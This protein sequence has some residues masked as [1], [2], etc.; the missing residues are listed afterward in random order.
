MLQSSILL[1]SFATP[2][3]HIVLAVHRSPKSFSTELLPS[4]IDLSLCCSPG[5]CS[6]V[7]D[8][9][10]VELHEVVS[11]LFQLIQVFLQGGCPF[12]TV[13]FPT[14]F[15]VFI[16]LC[17]TLG[18]IVQVTY[19]KLNSIGPNIYSW[20]PHSWQVSSFTGSC[21]SAPSECSL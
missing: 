10:F 14:W 15:G 12:W 16:R 5:L 8:L 17:V 4:Q 1:A 7:Q 20:S 3:A 6:R 9:M 21:F 13:N 2:C 11:P 19:E 18:P